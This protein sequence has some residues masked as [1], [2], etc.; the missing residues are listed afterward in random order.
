MRLLLLPFIAS[1]A[2]VTKDQALY[3]NYC[4]SCHGMPESG[5]LGPVISGS[6]RELLSEK[7]LFGRYPQG[8][9]PK[10]NTKSVPTMGY[11]LNTKD[12]NELFNYLNKE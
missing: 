2:D 1:C 3:N 7:V 8:Y 10:R 12:I 11:K 6:S 5:M 4:K 9:T